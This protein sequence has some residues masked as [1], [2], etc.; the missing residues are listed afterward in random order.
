MRVLVT[1]VAGFAGSHLADF[2]VQDRR[3]QVFGLD[4]P[5]CRKD[6]LFGAL[7]RIRFYEED[8]CNEAR[9]RKIIKQIKPELIFHLAAQAFVP[10]SWVL[11]ADSLN[12]NIIG[13][14]NILEAA[15][16]LKIKARIHIAGSAD[17]YGLV[18]KNELPVKE[19][20]PL[21]P[22]S[23]YAVGKLSQDMLGYQYFRSYGMY[24]VRTRAFNHI[25]PR[26]SERFA[27]SS[28]AKQ[29]ALI[30]K[31]KQK[32]VIYA[33]NLKAVRDFTDVRDIARAYWLCL[34]KCRPGEVYNICSGRGYSIAELL[35]TLLKLSHR[36]IEVRK[37]KKRFRPS[38]V[39]YLVGDNQKFCRISGWRPRVPLEET[40]KDILDYWRAR[41]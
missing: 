13:Q 19:T 14:L 27:A 38:D 35:K 16:E 6:N 40:L 17:E 9:V 7:K 26:M 2:L 24:I 11:P 25:G 34:N 41:V 32:P 12:T 28:F 5:G 22:L 20:N 8:I 3:R 37:D 36:S 1:G 21:R 30:E 10:D 33:G 23:P 15:R 18:Y 29:V 39:R 31:G 4:I